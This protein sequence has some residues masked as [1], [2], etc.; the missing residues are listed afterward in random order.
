MTFACKG[1][2]RLIPQANRPSDF[3][4]SQNGEG[5]ITFPRPVTNPTVFLTLCE[6]GKYTNCFAAGQS[7]HWNIDSRIR[8][9]SL[10]PQ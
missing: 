5:C 8:M 1:L 2:D 3:R 6:G 7:N 10:L 4:V 9:S